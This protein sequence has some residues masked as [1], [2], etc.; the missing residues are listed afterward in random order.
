MQDWALFVD[1]EDFEKALS[2]IEYRVARN[3][4]LK[5]GWMTYADLNIL[6]QTELLIDTWELMVSHVINVS[7]ACTAAY[8]ASLVTLVGSAL[9]VSSLPW[10]TSQFSTGLS[11]GSSNVSTSTHRLAPP[12]EYGKLSPQ[13][14]DD[15]LDPDSETEV[16]LANLTDFLILGRDT[17]ESS[18][19][20][21]PCN[22]PH[23][24]CKPD[25]MLTFKPPPLINGQQM[26]ENNFT[27][28]RH[29]QM[30]ELCSQIYTAFQVADVPLTFRTLT[31]C[32]AA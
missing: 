15:E 29:G 12:S 2:D 31:S 13:T 30:L 7:V 18:H 1:E 9:V 19:V 24:R 27:E 3:E 8:L 10:N 4:S 5:R 20:R 26:G 17:A 16:L 28:V 32:S 21:S 23:W 25:K 22:G 14:L 6:A 11:V